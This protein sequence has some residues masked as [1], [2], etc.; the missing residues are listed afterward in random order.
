MIEPLYH[1]KSVYE[2]FDVLAGKGRG[3]YDIV[4]ETWK[5]RHGEDGFEAFW[6]TAVHDGIV[7]G[8]AARKRDVTAD[9]SR[10]GRVQVSASDDGLELVLR[11]DPTVGAGRGTNNGWLQELPKPLTLLTWE[12]ALLISPALADRRG[13]RSGDVVKVSVG[14]R[15]VKVPVWVQPGLAT[16]GATLHLGYGRTSGGRIAPGIGVSAFRIQP[17]NTPWSVA[18]VKVGGVGKSVS[19]ASVQ[20]HHSME[21]RELVRHAT[22]EHFRAHPHFAKGHAHHG[23]KDLSLHPDYAY[24]GYK[25]GMVID[26]NRCIGCNACASACQAENNI[27]IVGKDEVAKGR[28]MQWIRVDRY[29]E[30]DKED[31]ATYHQP[32]PCMHCERAPCEVV[33]P[34]GATV[35]SDEGLNDMVYNRCVGTRYC[36]NNCPYKVRRFNFFDYPDHETESM[37]LQRNPDVT[38]RMRGVMEKC[39]YCVQRINAARVDA[40]NENRRIRDGEV[41]SACQQACPAGAIVFGDLNDTNS[42]VAK[43]AASELNYALLGELNTKPR[44]T[45]LAR[46]SNPN[47]ALGGRHGGHAHG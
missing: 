26:L 14:N 45:Y 34:V 11:P 24:E 31:P 16:G 41:Q 4:R 15:S 37:K 38:V 28:E 43:L 39:T 27:A 36:S 13:Y 3:S 40:K 30:G 22:L 18:G 9:A 33:C 2:L 5:T 32:V 19:L 10:I 12:N 7:G 17:A 42:R 8:T 44:T 35:H 6:K 25:W 1:G 23:D 29:F 20:N 21:G 46:L 47:P